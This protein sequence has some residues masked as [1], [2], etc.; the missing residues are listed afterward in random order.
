M[1]TLIKIF[2]MP[3]NDR[4]PLLPRLQVSRNAHHPK[5][6]SADHKT[7]WAYWQTVGSVGMFEVNGTTINSIAISFFVEQART[8]IGRRST[9]LK[10]FSLP[11]NDYL[12][13][14]LRLRV[15]LNA[16][17][18]KNSISI[19]AYQQTVGSPEQIATHQTGQGM[20]GKILIPRLA[21][22]KY[23]RSTA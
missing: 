12:P 19:R 23:L 8:G 14:L 16:Y 5:I 21:Q 10:I 20:C 1:S 3:W 17:H 11:W 22:L 7:I 18:P 13:L 2:S 6:Q 15:S 4:L 9:T